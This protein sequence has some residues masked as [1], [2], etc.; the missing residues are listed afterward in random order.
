MKSSIQPYVRWLA[1]SF[2]HFIS[3]LLQIVDIEK[4]SV[5]MLPTKVEI[6]LKKAEPGSWAQLSFPRSSDNKTE[7]REDESKEEITER[8]EAVDLS[9]L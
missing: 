5:S 1:N 7:S 2:I 9:D 3:S 8:V 4:S 6:K